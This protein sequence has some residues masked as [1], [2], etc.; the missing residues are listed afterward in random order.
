MFIGYCRTSS[1]DQVYGLEAQIDTLNEQGVEK[2][3]SEQVSSVGDRP[4]LE[5][6][7][8]FCREG[9]VLVVTK[10]DRLARS[11]HDLWRIV[12]QLE[13]KKVELRILDLNLDTSTPTG[14]LMLSM[15]GAL[16][17]FEREMLLER[18]REGIARAKAEGK[19]KGRVPI[20]RVKQA[21]IQKLIAEGVKPTK[22]AE[23]L[24][25]SRASVYRY[26]N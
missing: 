2:V 19:F 24:G 21:E 22:V 25:V 9:D 23:Q 10:L 15:M 11:I 8:E 4:E 20:A 1:Y 6:A 26:A 13:S 16:A 3:F 7:L 17:Q 14:R 18:Q 5:S 12:D